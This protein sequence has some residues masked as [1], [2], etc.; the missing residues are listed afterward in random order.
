M[1]DDEW[2]GRALALADSQRAST[3]PNPVVGCVVVSDGEV[4]GQGVTE[5]P[6]GRHA[7]VV[8]LAQ[9]GERARSSSV[10]TT[11]EPCDHHGRTG[12]CSVALVA[13]GVARVVVAAPDPSAHANGGAQR[14]REAGVDV[15]EGVMAEQA[16]ALNVPF[17]RAARE[18]RP[19]VIVKL[20]V[21]L[22]GRVAAADGTSQWLTGEQARAAAHRL[23][24]DVDA[25]VV[26]SG[27]A[28]SDDP[29]LTARLED[30]TLAARQPLR[31]VLDARAR[32]R[33][34]LRAYDDVAPSLVVTSPDAA[35]DAFDDAGVEVA[36]VD[37]PRADGTDLRALLRLL[38]ARGV[39][40]V[41]VEGGAMLASSFVAAGLAD[42]LLVHLAPLLLG[43]KG[44]AALDIAIPT[45]EAAPR[46]RLDRVQQVGQDAVLH[47]S[48]GQE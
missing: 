39:Q 16:R 48:P 38:G 9:A 10:Y 30:G 18:G 33:P 41:L 32:T 42:R 6:G 45:L 5:P 15:V 29:W 21:S 31:V 26:G 1:T 46:W 2:M 28:L 47:C 25:V 3:D 17:H 40:S 34:G 14:L 4:V 27:T 24:A 12:P 22:D 7:E 36:R 37:G 23:R 8:A 35:T 13:A 43:P 11:L 20:A 19:Q 44:L